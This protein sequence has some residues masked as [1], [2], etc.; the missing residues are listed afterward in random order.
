[1]PTFRRSLLQWIEDLRRDVVFG[2][3]TLARTRGFTAVAIT[4]LALGISAVTVI[5]SVVR[6]VVLDPFGTRARSGW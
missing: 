2:I 4:T 3:R 1:M 6:N 5:Y